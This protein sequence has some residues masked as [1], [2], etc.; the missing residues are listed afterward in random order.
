MC[1][2][3]SY[4]LHVGSDNLGFKMAANSRAVIRAKRFLDRQAAGGKIGRFAVQRTL[5]HLKNCNVV[6]NENVAEV[7]I[8]LA[9]PRHLY[10]GAQ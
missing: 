1:H 10:N 9:G 8:N 2:L 3:A 7:K 6:L 4:L 5:E